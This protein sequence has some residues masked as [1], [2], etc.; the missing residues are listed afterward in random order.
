MWVVP[1]DISGGD[2]E[3]N[4][5][6]RA[7]LRFRQ[8]PSS[9]RCLRCLP[10]VP[11]STRHMESKRPSSIRHRLQARPSSIWSQAIYRASTVLRLSYILHGTSPMTRQTRARF[12]HY[13]IYNISIFKIFVSFDNTFRRYIS[14]PYL[15]LFLF[16]CPSSLTSATLLPFYLT[17]ELSKDNS[18]IAKRISERSSF[19]IVCAYL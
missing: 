17:L 19:A 10:P 18:I 2:S 3:E 4:G 1:C 7:G 9:I 8:W 12:P 6:L 16:L 13:I 5:S 11:S 14:T 15:L